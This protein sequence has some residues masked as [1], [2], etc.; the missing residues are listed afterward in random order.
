MC[1]DIPYYHTMDARHFHYMHCTTRN[2]GNKALTNW[3]MARQLWDPSIDCEELWNDYFAGRYG[4]AQSQ[5]R[6]F[7]Q[8]LE[9]MLSNVSELKYELAWRLETGAE[10]LFPESHLKYEKTTF[11]TDDGP[12]LVEI[13]GSAARGR[14]I[15]DGVMD[16]ELPERIAQ[17][18]A[19]DERLFTYGERTVL[20]Y[21]A[22]VRA[23]FRI[24]QD[25][26]ADAMKAFQEAQT[27]A[28][29][30]KADTTSTRFSSSHASAPDALSASYAS[31]ALA[32]LRMMVSPAD[33][34][35]GE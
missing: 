27:F 15:L 3:Q 16:M 7:Y 4:P 35:E 2:W 32:V 26:Q 6:R 20:F 24:R 5:M 34:E 30:L 23:Y 12:D 28:A 33:A 14:K 1:N 11:K 22:L 21:D 25:K 17:R 10:N 9:A 29:L 13:L 8:H 18:V 19:E 31:D